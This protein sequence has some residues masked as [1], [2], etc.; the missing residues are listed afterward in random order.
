MKRSAYRKRVPGHYPRMDATQFRWHFHELDEPVEV[1]R[2]GRYFG[3]FL[4]A[5]VPLYNPGERSRNSSDDSPKRPM[6]GSAADVYWSDVSSTLDE[7]ERVL[8]N[9]EER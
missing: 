2:Y 8:D 3:T 9:G 6:R 1:V 7:I 5:R 4:P